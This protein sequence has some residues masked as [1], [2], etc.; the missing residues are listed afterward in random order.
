MIVLKYILNRTYN[1]LRRAMT[2]RYVLA[3]LVYL[4]YE[5]AI[6]V[7]DSREDVVFPSHV[8]SSF[9]LLHCINAVMYL[10]VWLD[11]QTLCNLWTNF[12]IPDWANLFSSLIYLCS[13]LVFPSD[14][15]PKLSNYEQLFL[16]SCRLDLAGSLLDMLAICGWYV[17]LYY[18]YQDEVARNPDVCVARGLTL[19]DPDVW[20][21]A[22]LT[23]ASGHYAYYNMRIN[24][25]YAHYDEYSGAY[26]AANFWYLVNSVLYTICAL[27]DC[28]VF[29]FMPYVGQLPDIASM[30]EGSVGYPVLPADVILGRERTSSA[31]NLKKAREV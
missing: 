11:G 13:V 27:R 6:F 25:D 28:D 26:D 14:L 1:G 2:N 19:D 8:G 31:A 12:F 5:C 7:M 3:N 24:H 18:C 30:A 20:A 4:F 17:Q 22:T 10:W 21:I 15:D 9:A 16:V 29:W 23:L